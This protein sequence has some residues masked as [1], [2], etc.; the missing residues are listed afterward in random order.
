MCDV[1]SCPLHFPPSHSHSF[2]CCQGSIFSR[3]FHAVVSGALRVDSSVEPKRF[4]AIM[5]RSLLLKKEKKKT[6]PVPHCT[7]LNS[8]GPGNKIHPF[9]LWRWCCKTGNKN[10]AVLTR[11]KQFLF[12][13][14]VGFVLL[15]GT[16]ALWKGENDLQWQ[17]HQVSFCNVRKLSISSKF[18]LLYYFIIILWIK[19]EL[20]VKYFTIRSN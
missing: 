17:S 20:N 19:W 10:Q 18:I 4:K 15:G 5:W 9:I 7:K 3:A 11:C 1:F 14:S 2:L 13:S 16:E 8:K 6:E 12:Y